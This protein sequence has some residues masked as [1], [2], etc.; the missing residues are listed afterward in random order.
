MVPSP[1]TIPGIA[2]S[3]GFNG[4]LPIQSES[5]PSTAMMSGW[6]DGETY[7]AR[8]PSVE[9]KV[10]PTADAAPVRCVASRLKRLASSMVAD[11]TMLIFEASSELPMLVTYAFEPA[12]ICV[13]AAD[14]VRFSTDPTDSTAWRAV[15]AVEVPPSHRN[16]V[17]SA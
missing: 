12:L 14:Q 1:E 9:T 4:V 5:S 6:K 17:F 7:A 16:S 10:I 2:S 13:V 8:V 15:V 3:D 11:A